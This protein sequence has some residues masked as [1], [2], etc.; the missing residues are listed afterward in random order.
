MAVTRSDVALL[1]GV[2]PAVVSYVIN[3][4]PRPVSPATRQRVESA[5]RELGY[6][7]NAIASALRGGA[8]R[9]VGLLTPGQH[10]P[11]YAE[12]VESVER[13][14]TELGYLVLTASTSQNRAQEERYLHSLIDRKVDA[15]L[16]SSSVTLAR[17]W[18]NAL[19]E[20]PVIVLDNVAEGS[21][22]SGIGWDEQGDAGSA[23]E[24]LQQHGYRSIGC[25]AGPPR[26][27]ISSAR[28][29]GWSA[30]QR[31]AGLANHSDLVAANDYSEEGGYAAAMALLHPR[32]DDRP[33][34]IYVSSDV[35]AVGVLYACF[36][37]GLRVP[38]DVAVVAH[39]GTRAASFTT[40][41]LTTLRQDLQ[42][43]AQLAASHA[44]ERIES[45]STPLLRIT[46]RGNLVIGQSCGCELVA[47][48]DV[49][50]GLR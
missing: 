25:V 22:L 2:S 42:Y 38:D 20:I 4:G 21:G 26:D 13:Q 45:L 8:T 11:Y 17:S 18:S 16:F 33:R 5:I 10:N 30:Q 6:R 29:A 36:E 1:A 9:S 37:L 46:L 40:P 49:G 31:L 43:V 7:P 12:L 24:H 27:P 35:Q 44:V 39:D 3:D 41:P 48:G 19:S 15:L 23:V 47:H 34:A 50:S 14:F 32:V 28:L